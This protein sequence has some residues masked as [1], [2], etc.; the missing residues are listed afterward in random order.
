MTFSTRH[1]DEEQITDLMV[2][3]FTVY[4]R[5]KCAEISHPTYYTSGEMR[6]NQRMLNIIKDDLI[7][8]IETVS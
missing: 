2:S 1:K 3:M 7:Q 8:L 5:N 4:D 6:R